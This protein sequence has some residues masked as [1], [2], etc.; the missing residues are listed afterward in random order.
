W[1]DSPDYAVNSRYWNSP[2]VLKEERDLIDRQRTGEPAQQAPARSGELA[3]IL[4]T[5]RNDPDRYWGDKALQDRHRALIEA[6]LNLL[7][8]K[9]IL[10]AAMLRLCRFRDRRAPCRYRH[11]TLFEAN[12]GQR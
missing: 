12:S 4:D 10:M 9:V 5:L 6:S 3:T 11:T 8:L 2:A 1:R 7:R